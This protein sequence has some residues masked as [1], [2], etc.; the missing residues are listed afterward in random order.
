MK[1]LRHFILARLRKQGQ[2]T[3]L[4]E[5]LARQQ[6]TPPSPDAPRAPLAER[7]FAEP[8]STAPQDYVAKYNEIRALYPAFYAAYRDANERSQRQPPE[9]NFEN[10]TFREILQALPRYAYDQL[11]V[12]IGNLFGGTVRTRQKKHVVNKPHGPDEEQFWDKEFPRA[13]TMSEIVFRK[14]A[15][16]ILGNSELHLHG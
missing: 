12:S 10:M 16:L 5:E 7:T 2:F 1:E 6:E 3:A 4:D 9:P 11:S 13:D 15:L 14:L 8:V